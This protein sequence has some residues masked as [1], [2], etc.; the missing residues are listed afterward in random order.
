MLTCFSIKLFT[1]GHHRTRWVCVRACFSTWNSYPLYECVHFRRN[2][3]SVEPIFK[4]YSHGTGWCEKIWWQVSPNVRSEASC[5]TLVLSCSPQTCRDV[6]FPRDAR[7]LLAEKWLALG[8]V[9]HR[10]AL[11]E[12]LLGGCQVQWATCHLTVGQSSLCWTK[13]NSGAKTNRYKLFSLPMR[14]RGRRLL[15]PNSFGAVTVGKLCPIW[16]SL[17][18]RNCNKSWRTPQMGLGS[19]AYEYTHRLSGLNW[20]FWIQEPLLLK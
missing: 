19:P 5:N 20:H 14:M 2:L 15:R 9:R 17:Y 16:E 4:T 8:A 1:L 7:W 6:A 18:L 10:S 13:K 12:L 3:N 11:C